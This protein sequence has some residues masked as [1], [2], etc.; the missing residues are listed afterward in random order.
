[1]EFEKIISEIKSELIEYYD[2]LKNEIDIKVQSLFI[3]IEKETIS[4]LHQHSNLSRNEHLNKIYAEFISLCDEIF[5]RSMNEL[6]NFH[7]QEKSNI[8][9]LNCKDEIKNAALSS[10]CMFVNNDYFDSGMGNH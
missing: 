9:H 10:S 5:N 3:S 7:L 8:S 6:N 4:N 1:M 2:S